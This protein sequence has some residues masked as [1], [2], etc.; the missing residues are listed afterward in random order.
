MWPFLGSRNL[1]NIYVSL[2]DHI[3]SLNYD[4]KLIE[5]QK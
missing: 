5:I 2:V 4:D 1:L 3:V